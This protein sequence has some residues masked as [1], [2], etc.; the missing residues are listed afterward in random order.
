MF[1]DSYAE[2]PTHV[3]V[4][5]KMIT[6]LKPSNMFIKKKYNYYIKRC[7]QKRNEN[8]KLPWMFIRFTRK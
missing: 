7:T 6:T 2:M 8:V 5:L 4:I 1:Q 3:V